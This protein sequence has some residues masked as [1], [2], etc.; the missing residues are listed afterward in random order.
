A[1]LQNDIR[2]LLLGDRVAD[3]HCMRKL[4]RMCVGQFRAGEGRAM[5]PIASRPSAH[6]DDRIA[7]ARGFADLVARDETDAAAENQRIAEISLV[8]IDRAVDGGDANAVAVVAHAGDDL[9]QDA[10]RMNDPAR[11]RPQAGLISIGESDAKY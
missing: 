3:L 4:V 5:N 2:H 11:E 8:K 1:R 10:S 7:I 9:L 6:D